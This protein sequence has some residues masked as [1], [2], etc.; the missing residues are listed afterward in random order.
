MPG[1]LATRLPSPP[2]LPKTRLPRIGTGGQ[3]AGRWKGRNKKINVILLILSGI[4]PPFPFS[5]NGNGYQKRLKIRIVNRRLRSEG[6]WQIKDSGKVATPLFLHKIDKV[7][8][9]TRLRI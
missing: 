2:P 6:L 3:V 8:L 7:P 9:F 5:K 1:G 4:L